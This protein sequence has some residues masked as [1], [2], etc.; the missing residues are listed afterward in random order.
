M[1]SSSE[2]RYSNS[3]P[4]DRM[5][6]SS[7][8]H[9]SGDYDDRPSRDRYSSGRDMD[10]NNTRDRYDS[11]RSYTNNDDYRDSSYSRGGKDSY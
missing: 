4:S 9:R 6:E 2:R 8:S 3:Y 11:R 5:R 7:S 10:R 1:S